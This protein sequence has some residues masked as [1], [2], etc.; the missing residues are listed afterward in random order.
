[1]L[2]YIKE[3]STTMNRRKFISSAASLAVLASPSVR[4]TGKNLTTSS[5]NPLPPVKTSSGT[6]IGQSQAGG[7]RVWKGI[8]Y[9]TPPIGDLRGRS[10]TP[11]HYQ[12]SPIY[13]FDYG[14]EAVQ[15]GL[16]PSDD[17][18]LAGSEDCLYLNIWSPAVT[19]NTLPVIVWIHGGGF[20]QGSSLDE[21]FD[22]S[23]YAQTGEVVFVSI[24]YRLGGFGYL[25]PGRYEGYCNLGLEDQMAALR[26]IKANIAEF[27]GDRNN[28]TVM[29]ESAGAMSIG[30]LAGTPSAAGLF[31]KAIIQSGGMRP[32]WTNEDRLIMQSALC[33][34]LKI[35]ENEIEKIF[36]LSTAEL[37]K[38]F[39]NLAA[40]SGNPLMGGEAFHPG[41]DGV[42]L[43]D[44]PLK[45]VRPIPLLIGH[46]ANEGHLFFEVGPKTLT[47][48][49]VSKVRDK[50]GEN[51]WATIQDT[52]QR[53][54]DQPGNQWVIDLFSDCFVGLA[55][56][57]L[58]LAVK[59]VGGQAW[60]YRYDYNNASKLGATHATDIALTFGR[61][62][63]TPAPLPWTPQTH[64]LS[65]TMRASFIHFAIH[66]VAKTAGV[67]EWPEYDK[68]TLHFVSFDTSVQLKQDFLGK[69][70]RQV[71]ENVSIYAV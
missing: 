44:H 48:G 55:S 22:G 35:S 64:L 16:V 66:G 45:N 67:D 39:I 65:S 33:Q 42:V 17:Q 5:R 4:A 51:K 56:H 61:P 21:P 37:N 70:R 11:L 28:I 34:E 6:I 2:K 18:K 13:A 52:Y 27:G 53:S 41:I 10:P 49:L 58:A 40:K 50:V 57:R 68:D 32:V 9:A 38:A 8:P 3:T 14:N 59:E 7:G 47:S 19:A 63:G 43:P 1:M 31:D 26:W 15:V 36:T 25:M 20:V 60:C 30:I 29:G 62:E 46:C 24:N 12:H 54:A 69:S 71:W 23:V